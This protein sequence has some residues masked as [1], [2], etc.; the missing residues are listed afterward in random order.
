MS[1]ILNILFVCAGNTCRSPMAEAI[2]GHLLGDAAAVQSAGME[3]AT[4]MRAAPEAIQ[5]MKERGL[6]ISQHRTREVTSLRL[7]DFDLIVALSPHLQTSLE[8]LA[9]F[10][11]GKLRVLCIDDP[12]QRGIAEYRRC[13]DLLERA[14]SSLVSDIRHA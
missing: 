1:R 8:R 9:G 5:V 6:D 4:G 10:D 13:A 12:Y 2:A 14:L 11:R 3:T 7:A